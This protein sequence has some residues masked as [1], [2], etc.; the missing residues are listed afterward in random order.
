MK[1]C[2]VIAAVLLGTCLTANAGIIVDDRTY[3][4]MV[5]DMKVD[6]IDNLKVGE[7]RIFHFMGITDSGKAGIQ[8][9]AK[10]GNITRIHHVDAKVLTILG[11]GFT[12]IKVYGE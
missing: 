8:D 2:L 4:L 12:T 6:S 11:V 10:N 7:A 1:K 9:A 5:T 3:P